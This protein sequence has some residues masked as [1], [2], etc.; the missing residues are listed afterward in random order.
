[1]C[2]AVLKPLIEK[3]KKQDMTVFSL[4]YDNFKRL[5]SVYASRL[6][7]EDGISDLT[8]FLIELLYSIDLSR[9]EADETFG[10][11]KYIAVSIRNK[12]IALSIQKDADTNNALP[13]FEVA[14]PVHDKFDDTVLVAQALKVLNQKQKSVLIYKYV[15]GY[16][17]CE[18]A[19]AL[20]ITRQA[21]NGLKNRALIVL[22]ELLAG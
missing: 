15:Y 11:K 17:D 13:L 20:G 16:S 8:L 22:K 12:Y 3:F 18:I 5:I 2:N 4:I 1:M 21:V 7:Y 10:I 19:C 6:F 14:V 9:F